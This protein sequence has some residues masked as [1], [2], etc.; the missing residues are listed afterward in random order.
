MNSLTQNHYLGVHSLSPQLVLVKQTSLSEEYISKNGSQKVIHVVVKNSP[1]GLTFGFTGPSS[2]SPYVNALT[3]LHNY[4]VDI[5]LLYDS[6]LDKEVDF[7]KIS[8]L[9]VK[10]TLNQTGTKL[11]LEVRIKVLTSH[12]ENSLFRVGV[13]VSDQMTKQ[14]SYTIFSEAIKVISKSDQIK[15]KKTSRKKRNFND[16]LSDTLVQ[17]ETKQMEHAKILE[18]LCDNNHSFLE[19][20]MKAY[21]PKLPPPPPDFQTA[22]KDFLRS[23]ITLS[24]EDKVV[25]I[26]KLAGSQNT[27][28]MVELMDLFWAEG[29]SRDIR[30]SHQ[31]RHTDVKHGHVDHV[32]VGPCTCED[33]PYKKELHRIE[34]FYDDIFYTGTHVKYE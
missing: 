17:I 21:P 22:F 3:D 7:L 24:K 9:Q 33:C 2:Q 19:S 1:F 8:P 5:K 31:P 11:T 20:T 30:E 16:L 13:I 15:K 6:E 23:Y 32:E 29:L 18:T 4:N 25:K 34:N 10:S 12:M 14:G 28:D 26:R 27:H